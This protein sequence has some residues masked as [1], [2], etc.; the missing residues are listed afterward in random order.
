MPGF[1]FF[2]T[3]LG[4]RGMVGVQQ[5]LRA[6]YAAPAGSVSA[7]LRQPHPQRPH[8]SLPTP[9]ATRNRLFLPAEDL[10]RVAD[11]HR[12]DFCERLPA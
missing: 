5:D 9:G 1:V 7:G 4:H 11:P 3:K 12:V 6:R 10:Q 2:L 8:Q